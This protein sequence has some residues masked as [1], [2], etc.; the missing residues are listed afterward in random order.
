M[1]IPDCRAGLAEFRDMEELIYMADIV[2]E[3]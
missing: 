3:L 2:Y 1:A